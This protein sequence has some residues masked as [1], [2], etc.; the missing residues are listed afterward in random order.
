MP[1]SLAG[2][3]NLNI[4]VFIFS[5][6]IEP[7]DTEGD[8]GLRADFQ[9]KGPRRGISRMYVATALLPRIQPFAITI[10]RSL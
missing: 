10:N 6:V 3:I 2:A 8:V 9:R 5:G 1:L 7:E 4:A